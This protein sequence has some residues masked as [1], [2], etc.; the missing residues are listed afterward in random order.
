MSSIAEIPQP[1]TLRKARPLWHVSLLMFLLGAISNSIGY[2][3]IAPTPVFMIY[4]AATVA[5]LKVFD[6]SGKDE[7][8]AVVL[9]STICWFWA[10]IAAIYLK[11]V[12]DGAWG[13]D[14]PRFYEAMTSGE[15]AFE[16]GL[17]IIQYAGA[18]A[19]W[20]FFYDTFT[21]FGFAMGEYIGVTANVIFVA[22]TGMLGIKMVKAAFGPD[23]VR[24]R[25]FTIVFS[26]CGMFWLFAATHLRD[27]IVL[28]LVTLLYL[29][30]VS[31]LVTPSARTRIQLLIATLCGFFFFGLL[32]SEFVFVPIAMI[33][34]GVAAN[35]FGR[36]KGSKRGIVIVL[37]SLLVALPLA[38][39]LVSTMFEDIF[40]SL[41][42]GGERYD[43]VSISEDGSASL[44]NTFIV[45][46]PLP[47]RL[48]FG[49]AYVYLVP[50]PFWVG[51]MG[52]SVYHLFKSFH[53]LFMYAV[54]P[55]FGL[56]LWR[57]VTDKSLRTPAALFMV[58]CLCG[59]TQSVVL[60]SLEGR[61]LGAFIV[62]LLVLAV[63]PDMRKDADRHAYRF[64]LF[65]ML[66]GM[67][68]VHLT[69]GALKLL[70]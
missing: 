35:I 42:S 29:F 16:D 66:G 60:T 45:T 65:V 7:R 54:M 18:V 6:S 52:D 58:F 31:Y 51:L 43:K 17:A 22:L 4:L 64:L 21:F 70:T 28:F 2:L 44:G 11:H 69:W 40:N 1:M 55:L 5:A 38:V 14:A 62:P 49:S 3:T 8:T 24:V 39:F 67:L 32:R 23:P 37:V 56:A 50:I 47:V 27:A 48:V 57:L 41:S 20:R 26:W 36:Q 33:L 59:F 46:A 25:R 30:W 15:V 53:V 68:S 61:H 63:L 12:S 13:P 19:I 34:A 9:I 10:G